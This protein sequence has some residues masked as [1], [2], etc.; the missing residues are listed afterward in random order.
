MDYSTDYEGQNKSQIRDSKIWSRVPRDS[1]PRKTALGR[2]SS[3][4]KRQTHPL[5]KEG[6]PQKQDCNCRTVIAKYLVISPR[7]GSTPRLTD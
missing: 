5:V 1:N 7:W 6:A 3:I 4:Y 2:P